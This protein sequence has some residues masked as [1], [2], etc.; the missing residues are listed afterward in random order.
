[1]IFV[2][3]ASAFASPFRQELRCDRQEPQR[4]KT[5]KIIEDTEKKELTPG[6]ALELADQIRRGR[7]PEAQGF[8]RVKEA[9][10]RPILNSSLTLIDTS[11]I[12]FAANAGTL[13]AMVSSAVNDNKPTIFFILPIVFPPVLPLSFI[14]FIVFL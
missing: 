1:M 3:S 6:E 8:A 11:L 13:M 2:R 9:Y 4:E 14:P 10:E 7:R 5:V 12:F